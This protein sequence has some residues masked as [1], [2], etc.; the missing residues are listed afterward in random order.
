[1]D[2]DAAAGPPLETARVARAALA[3]V[4]PEPGAPKP[5][6]I[7]VRRPGAAHLRRHHRRRRRPRRGPAR[8]DHRADRTERRRQDHVLQPAD[9][10]RQARPAASG[11]STASRWPAWPPHKVARLGMVRTF[12]LTKSLTKL[13]VIENMKLGATDQTRREV[14]E[15]S[16]PVLWRTQEARDRGARRRAARP[17]QARPHARRVRRLAVGRPAQAARDGAGADD[18][19]EA[20]HAR[21]AD[22]RREPGA[23]A[24]PQRAHQRACA[25]RA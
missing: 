21:R 13:S 12:Q 16:V 18:R 22:G 5:D 2:A 1:M 7:L 6:P 19:P 8:L 15:R 20:G 3:D 24:E 17:L 10:L 25:T 23:Q 4:S 14:V 9:R 11:R